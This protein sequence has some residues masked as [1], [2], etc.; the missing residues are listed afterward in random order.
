MPDTSQSKPPRERRREQHCCSACGARFEVGHYGDPLE[1][2]VQVDVRCPRC[3]KEHT[4]SVP[5]GT[6][7]DLLV[8]LAAGPAPDI[9]GGAGGD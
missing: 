3:G 8:E 7:K 6:E 1:T 2:S 9:G 4:V 5:R